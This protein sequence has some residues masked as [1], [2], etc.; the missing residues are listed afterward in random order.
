[1][2]DIRE[3]V[4]ELQN[5]LKNLSKELEGVKEHFL[6][7]TVEQ[8]SERTGLPKTSIYKLVKEKTIDSYTLGKRIMVKLSPKENGK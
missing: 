1:M 4:K 7:E 8:A 2:K 6:Y 3:T 5:A